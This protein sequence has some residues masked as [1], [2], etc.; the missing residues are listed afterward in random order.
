MDRAPPPART[1]AGIAL[2]TVG[3]APVM[4]DKRLDDLQQDID[5]ARDTAEDAGILQDPDEKK[6]YESGSIRPDLDDQTIT[7]PG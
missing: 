2:L 7:P 5:Q 1:G 6:Y 3:Y 4:G